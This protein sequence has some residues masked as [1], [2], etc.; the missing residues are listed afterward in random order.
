MSEK[1]TVFDIQTI[2]DEL[3]IIFYRWINGYHTSMKTY[4]FRNRQAYKRAC[5]RLARKLPYHAPLTCLGEWLVR[6]ERETG[7]R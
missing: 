4:S 1:R 7:T 3:S 6:G 2:D 5:E